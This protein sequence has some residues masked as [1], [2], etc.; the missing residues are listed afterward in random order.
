MDRASFWCH[1][2]TFF[3]A[4]LASATAS[5]LLVVLAPG[6]LACRLVKAVPL[7]LLC[8]ARLRERQGRLARFVG[9]GLFASLVADV[10]I[11][12]VFVA[13]LGAFLVAHL[14]YIAGMGLPERAVGAWLPMLPALAFGGLMWGILVGAGRAPEALHA[15]ITAY[16]LVISSMLGRAL[17]RAFVEPKDHASRIFCAGAIFFVISDSLIGANRWVFPLPLGPVWILSTYWLGQF[18]I[19]RGSMPLQS[20]RA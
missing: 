10:V 20:E 12:N 8:V 14:F 16:A 7:F 17:G 2:A 11:D 15:P 6:S 5:C 9:L 4:Y 19:F 13:G 18:L 3:G 1:E